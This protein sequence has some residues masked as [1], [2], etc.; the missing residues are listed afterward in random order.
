MSADMSCQSCC[1]PLKVWKASTLGKDNPVYSV[2]LYQVQQCDDKC[3]FS[4]FTSGSHTI[5]NDKTGIIF[6]SKKYIE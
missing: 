2:Q 5:F 6:I 1:L 4:V 3:K